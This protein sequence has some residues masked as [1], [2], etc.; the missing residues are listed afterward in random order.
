M[1][2]LL[3][4]SN[5]PSLPT[6]QICGGRGPGYF[7]ILPKSCCRQAGCQT[8][9]ASNAVSRRFPRR[10]PPEN[11]FRS[12]SSSAILRFVHIL[13]RSS[14]W[15]LTYGY[16]DRVLWPRREQESVHDNCSGVVAFNQLD[17]SALLAFPVMYCREGR[18]RRLEL[19][20]LA[21][22]VSGSG[23]VSRRYWYRGWW[24]DVRWSP[25]S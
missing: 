25:L 22:D 1:L 7:S 19:G 16:D 6:P 5:A 10:C 21:L 23:E 14:T 2:C 8:P 17:D 15:S 11:V 3:N 20:S 24:Y 4:L 18:G 9:N 12:S 13:A